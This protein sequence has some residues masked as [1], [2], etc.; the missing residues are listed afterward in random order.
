MGGPVPLQ[1]L[2]QP[3]LP[4]EEDPSDLTWRSCLRLLWP[5][6]VPNTRSQKALSGAVLLLIVVAKL[7]NLLTP[8]ALRSVVN[9]LS[10]DDPLRTAIPGVLVLCG[11]T[12]AAD[13]CAQ[14]QTVCWG[15]LSFQI[16]QRVSVML[17]S[18]L[19]ALSLRW[20]LQRQTGSVLRVMDLGVAAVAQI[21]QASTEH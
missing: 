4:A 16:T 13:A 6:M 8:V 18:H 3:L 17:F 21:I 2:K 14:L 11:I 9:G 19:H 10:S 15:R 12:V 20:H 1:A 5:Q 7:L